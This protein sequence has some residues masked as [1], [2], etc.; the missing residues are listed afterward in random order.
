MKQELYIDSKEYKRIRPL[1]KKPEFPKNL[2]KI[3]IAY[4]DT[5]GFYRYLAK[6]EKGTEIF[7]TSIHEID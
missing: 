7:I 3:D 6:K 1:S 2:L 5:V 4:I